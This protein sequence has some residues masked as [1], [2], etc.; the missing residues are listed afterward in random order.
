[1]HG[2]VAFVAVCC[3]L[4]ACA[5]GNE[6]TQVDRD[7]VQHMLRDVSGDVKEHYYDAS[8]H[9]LDWDARVTAAKEEIDKASSLN[10]AMS[11]VAGV[12]DSLSDSHTFFLT[13]PRAFRHDYGWRW[14]VVGDRC[15]ITHVRP[16]SDAEAKGLKPGDEILGVNGF[17]AGRDSLWKI[18]YVFKNLRPQLGLR[19][20]AKDLAGAERQ[21][22]VLAHAEPIVG[23]GRGGTQD[24]WDIIRELEDDSYRMRAQYLLSSGGIA[25]VRFPRFKFSDDKV[26]ELIDK[27]R[28]AHSL[29]L[30]LRGNHGGRV[31]T[32]KTL[33]GFLF[34]REVKIGDRV[35]RD[36]T[37]AMLAT[38]PHGDPFKGKL[39][40]LVDSAS[41]SSSEVLARVV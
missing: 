5:S 20:L 16:G 35:E 6:F 8:L 32:L 38:A 15:L 22:D 12:L 1:M 33:I 13:P 34:G 26:G 37:E 3:A 10:Q 27:I 19:L 39:V 40:V 7:R 30:D 9:G 25:I 41:A 28:G 24:I 2:G 14:Q 4:F 36:K 23:G 17:R 18:E 11:H 21:L 29:V 31:Q